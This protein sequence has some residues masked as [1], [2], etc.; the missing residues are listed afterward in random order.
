MVLLRS[1]MCPDARKLKGDAPRV[2]TGG[3]KRVLASPLEDL[4]LEA[5]AEPVLFDLEIV[6]GLEI[7]P[8]SLRRAEVP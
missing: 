1:R 7:E 6:A 8:E 2:C 4:R 3:S 5:L